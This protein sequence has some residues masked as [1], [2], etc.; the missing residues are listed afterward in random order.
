MV[1]FVRVDDCEIVCKGLYLV[2][3]AISV[4]GLSRMIFK[5]L[6]QFSSRLDVAFRIF[7]G[8]EPLNCVEVKAFCLTIRV[9]EYSSAIRNSNVLLLQSVLFRSHLRD[10]KPSRVWKI[11]SIAQ[12]ATY[13]QKR[14]K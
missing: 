8:Q 13:S 11:P 6:W 10:S 5:G 2:F 1:N 4:L 9:S 3:G 12:H 7:P 14:R